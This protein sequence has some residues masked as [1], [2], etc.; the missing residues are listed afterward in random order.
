MHVATTYKVKSSIGD[1]V[2]Y[3]RKDGGKWSRSACRCDI[4]DELLSRLDWSVD[5]DAMELV[6]ANMRVPMAFLEAR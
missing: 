1:R 4:M 3:M 6:G 2:E 5:E